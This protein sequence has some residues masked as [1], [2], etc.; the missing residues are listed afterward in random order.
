MA[1]EN[2]A[3]VFRYHRLACLLPAFCALPILVVL[4]WSA[5][6]GRW[7]QA[8]LWLLGLLAYVVA[9]AGYLSSVRF[10]LAPDAVMRT[11]LFRPQRRIAFPDLARIVVKGNQQVPNRLVFR[12]SGAM[13]SITVYLQMLE[14]RGPELLD[15]ARIIN[16]E[17]RL[18]P[19][20]SG[21]PS[22]IG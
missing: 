5:I 12:G 8:G 2:G 16:E 7:S 6:D 18:G 14:K 15:R 11:S 3:A 19:E 10:S 22:R 1:Q 13:A 4:A 9:H 17:Q 20:E 21:N